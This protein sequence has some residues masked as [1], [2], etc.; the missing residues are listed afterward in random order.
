MPCC[1]GLRYT[2]AYTAENETTSNSNL[3]AGPSGHPWSELF[4]RLHLR[5]LIVIGRDGA[6]EPH[7]QIIHYAAYLSKDVPWRFAV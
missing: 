4:Y 2:P 7:S 6:N 1:P 5:G 3:S